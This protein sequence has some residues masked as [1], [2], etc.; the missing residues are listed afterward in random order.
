[1]HGKTEA[2]ENLKQICIREEQP[3]AYWKYVSC[4]LNSSSSLECVTTAGIDRTKL[5][6]CITDPTRGITYAEDDFAR[7]ESYGVTGS[8]TLFLNGKKV[9][10]F[11]FGGRNPEAVKTLVC[12]GF[13]DQPGSCSTR[14]SNLS[15][16]ASQGSC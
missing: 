5:D 12:C 9:S 6:S 15:A 14:L 4:F 11:N 3:D 13:S 1:M 16:S 10:E 2:A 8:P 7:E